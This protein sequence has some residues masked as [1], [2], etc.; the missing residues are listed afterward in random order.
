VS[1]V[2]PV[3]PRET[4]K[5]AEALKYIEL[6]LGSGAIAMVNLPDAE[7]SRCFYCGRLQ[8]D[9]AKECESCGAPQ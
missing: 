6:Y 5:I 1:F 8:N 4:D 3:S 9:D 7:S 2:I